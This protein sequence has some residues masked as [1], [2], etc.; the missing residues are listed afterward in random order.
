M[1]FPRILHNSIERYSSFAL[2]TRA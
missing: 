1:R 2:I